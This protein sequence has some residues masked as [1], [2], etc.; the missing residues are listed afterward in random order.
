[1]SV[2][3]CSADGQVGRAVG[4]LGPAWPGF[5]VVD[6]GKAGVRV[7]GV[8]PGP[9]RIVIVATEAVF[10][11]VLHTPELVETEC[12]IGKGTIDYTTVLRGAKA[13]VVGSK[14]GSICQRRAG[15]GVALLVPVRLRARVVA[16]FLQELLVHAHIET[17]PWKKVADAVNDVGLCDVHPVQLVPARNGA[18][19]DAALGRR[20]DQAF[21]S[22]KILGLFVIGQ[23]MPDLLL[24]D[25][26]QAKFQK[27]H[28]ALRWLTCVQV[29]LPVLDAVARHAEAKRPRSANPFRAK[30]M[31]LPRRS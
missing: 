23:G 3:Y 29:P 8:S 20:L 7:C 17:V 12:R 22:T 24:S 2:T 25:V 16:L 13:Q 18:V 4:I 31:L 11:G 14:N 10:C 5:G 1:M 9:V 19:N 26:I 15:I 27:T 21:L 6:F 28:H 30:P